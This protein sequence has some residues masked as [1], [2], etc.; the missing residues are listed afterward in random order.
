[1]KEV[2]MRQIGT[3]IATVVKDIHNEAVIKSV[4]TSV[5]AMS[6]KFTLHPE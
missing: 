1:M 6:S 5:T 4:H 3:W 2:E